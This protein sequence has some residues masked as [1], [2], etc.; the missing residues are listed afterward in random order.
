MVRI[1][2]KD[3]LKLKKGQ[4]LYFVE[5]HSCGKKSFSNYEYIGN[6]RDKDCC[7]NKMFIFKPLLSCDEKEIHC[8]D[9]NIIKKHHQEV[10]FDPFFPSKIT[11]VYLCKVTKKEEKKFFAEILANK[12]I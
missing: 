9:V 8:Y 6:K 2:H 1:Y 4:L 10:E 5:E 3:F 12:I 7:Y 11:K